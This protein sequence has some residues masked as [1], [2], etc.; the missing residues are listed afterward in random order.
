MEAAGSAVIV[1][2][3][4]MAV[5]IVGPEHRFGDADRARHRVALD[6]AVAALARDLRTNGEDFTS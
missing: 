2:S 1:A 5:S 3:A 4:G 6:G